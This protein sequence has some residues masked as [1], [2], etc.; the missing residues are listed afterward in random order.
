MPAGMHARHF[1]FYSA[2]LQKLLPELPYAQHEK[3]F[4]ETVGCLQRASNDA[5]HQVWLAT[6]KFDGL[7]ALLAA[8][9]GIIATYHT[10]PYRLLPMWLAK[11]GVPFTLL[12]S[13]DVEASEGTGYHAWYSDIGKGASE[14]GFAILEAEDP[15]VVRKMA[16][17]LAKGHFLL[18]YVDGNTG[19]GE[20]RSE[21]AIDFLAHRIRIRAGTAHVAHLAKV[22]I[23]PV[24]SLYGKGG[25]PS[26][27]VFP[28]IVPAGAHR[29]TWSADATRRVYACLASVLREN[30]GQWEGWLYVHGDIVIEEEEARMG[31]FR[32]FLPFEA[33]GQGFLL[34]K[35]TY[36]AYPL[37]EK[38]HA[39]LAD[40]VFLP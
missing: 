22:P 11:Q 20:A 13:A 36:T 18:V 39:W 9:P 10:G 28:P 6:Q 15:L 7:Q 34:N 2:N 30:P 1:A 26:F 27:R 17:A 14:E 25:L 33:N 31:L 21:S 4:E 16:R 29:E 32:L 8:A 23:Y 24:A 35:E 19:S 12:V 5:L 40:K 38:L 37:P 3:L